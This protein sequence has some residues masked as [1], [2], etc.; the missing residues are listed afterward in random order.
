MA[1]LVMAALM[2]AVV[3]YG[4]S[5]ASK[6]RGGPAYRAFRDGLAATKLVSARRTGTVAA[7]L[8]AAE[9]VVASLCAAALIMSVLTRPGA[10]ATF[11]LRC[12]ALACAAA[13]TAVLTAGVATVVHRGVT[14]PC[15]CFGSRG[16]NPLSAVHVTRNACLLVVLIAGVTG[17]AGRLAAGRRRR[18]ARRG[19]RRR[20][21]PGAHPP[22][23]PD[24]AVRHGDG[25]PL[26][27]GTAVG[28]GAAVCVALSV[29]GVYRVRRRL[30]VVEVAGPSMT[31]A[32]SSGD[33]V[34]IRRPA[35]TSCGPA[36]SSSWIGRSWMA[37]GR[38]RR[39]AGRPA[40]GTG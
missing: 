24:G 8:V 18:D 28:V 19:H 30:A 22:R 20:G 29:L 3:T 1:E 4:W 21:G 38:G 2:T 9:T 17:R 34:L 15:A 14:A 11:A 33:R 35:R 39:Q 25:G 10:P 5:A 40:D 36:W 31:P 12:T 26:M 6:L 37:H 7:V 32:L 16:A 27:P 13:L 23:R